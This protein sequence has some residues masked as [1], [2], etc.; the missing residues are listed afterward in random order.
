MKPESRGARGGSRCPWRRVG[1]VLI[2]FFL[3]T[4]PAVAGLPVPTFFKEFEPDLI[5]P[6]STS[7]LTFQIIN[8]GPDPVTDLAFTDNLPTGVV[9]ATPTSAFTSCT[10]G[11]LTAPAGGTT[12]DF[13]GGRLGGG[14]SCIVSVNV[15]SSVAETYTNVSGDLTSSAGNSGSA[16]ADLTV[17][18]SR[19]GFRKSFEPAAIAPHHSSTLTLTID[20]SANTE[21]SNDFS[22]TDTLPEGLQIASPANASTD[23]DNSFFPPTLTALPGTRAIGLFNG[24]VA[25]NSSC[26]VTVDVTGDTPAAYINNS[27]ELNV[28]FPSSGTAGFATA[29]LDVLFVFLNKIFSDDP[30]SPGQTVTLEFTATNTDR[31]NAATDIS[32]TDDLGAT[33]AG[34]EAVGLPLSDVCGPGSQIDGTSVL[35][36]TGGNIGPGDSCSFSVTLQVPGG[37]G[38][39]TYTNTT[40]EVTYDLDG[41]GITEDPATDFLVVA[42]VPILSK[43][44]IDDPV[45]PGASVTLEFTIENPTS[46][47]FSE[48]TFLDNLT[49]VTPG[50]EPAVGGVPAPGFCGPGSSAFLTGGG[51]D[52]LFLL[53]TE[54]ELAAGSSCTFQVVLDIPLGATPGS[55]LNT[56]S[57]ITGFADGSDPVEGPPASDILEVAGVPAPAFSKAFVDN[58]AIAG[59]AATL[60]FTIT[61]ADGT[62]GTTDLAFTDDLTA[63]LP[64]LVATGLPAADICG[65]G[66]TLEGTDELTF[67]GGS[68]S[69]TSSCTFQVTLV[70]PADATTGIYE[71]VTSTLTGETG[72][73]PF[74]SL[75]ATSDLVIEGP[76]SATKE[77]TDD[78]VV[79]GTQVTLEFT[80]TNSD[81]IDG[82][83]GISF[84]DDL[85]GVLPGLVAVGLPATNLCGPGSVLNGT[86]LLSFIG[87][88]LVPGGSCTFSVTLAVPGGTPAGAYVN[89][90]SVINAMSGGGPLNALPASDTLLVASGSS[91][92]LSKSFTDDP[93][94][95][96]GTATLEFSVDYL[97]G[98][99][100][101]TD[102]AFTDDLE[103]AL[104]GLTAVGLPMTDVCGPGSQIN[105][106]SLLTLSDGS[107]PVGGSCTFQVTVLVPEDAL[108]GSYTNVTSEITGND[109]GESINGAPASDDLLVTNGL[110]FNKLTNGEDADA[111]T[112]PMID[113]GDPVTW[114]YVL[115]NTGVVPAT[116]IEVEDSEGVLVSCPQDMLAP[117]ETLTCTGSGIATL[118]QYSNVGT[119]SLVAG[120]RP[121]VLTDP[122]HYLGVDT[123]PPQVVGVD[124]IPDTGDGQLE[125]CETAQ[126][127]IGQIL[128]TFDEPVQDPPG[129]SEP[130]DVT[131]PANYLLV[132]AGS[133]DDIETLEC[134]P[135][136]GDDLAIPI[137]M[138]SYD[139]GSLTATLDLGSSLPDSLH[140]LLVCGST[141]IRDLAGN[142]LDGNGD[143]M[144]G[145]DYAQI[146]RS[147]PGNLLANGHFDCSLVDWTVS[148]TIPGSVTHSTADI[149]DSSLSGAAEIFVADATGLPES[150]ALSQCLPVPAAISRSL[151]GWTRLTA[152]PGV[153]VGFTESCEFFDQADCN[154]S[155]LGLSLNGL[156]LQDTGGEWVLLAGQIEAPASAVS[157]LCSFQFDSST[158]NAFEA[159]LDSTRLD[160][161]MIFA[162]GFE[163]GD[164]SAWS[165]TE[166]LQ[167]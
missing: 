92:S 165:V 82:V 95:P 99:S 141:S 49:Q 68:L 119:A 39:D 96:G 81:I 8:N 105:G 30:V 132:A 61:T 166:P 17:D 62:E 128:V 120:T 90:T 118:G 4:L 14:G 57:Q 27:G 107:L 54:A 145:D 64:G 87:G 76:L 136:M 47:D 80:L 98:A 94:P 113:V 45:D 16:T 153:F 67:S 106:S 112:G 44:F 12:I 60:Q 6:G 22:F 43:S 125:D 1:G 156:L 78:P 111:P 161:S 5:G 10:D 65:S 29:Q 117:G 127:A 13:S 26:T 35:T 144:G 114:E 63:V 24:G 50:L 157:A 116:D 123:V 159:L 110:E 147:D 158:G 164:T 143:G 83:T 146:F 109:G 103:A 134:G 40:S 69:P 23:C 56:T 86:S 74:T 77:F 129:D 9:I 155:S 11:V 88:E 150:F 19:P 51:F 31:D 162:D 66:S 2:A 135:L 59:G 104:N 151:G 102:I 20:N 42:P 142:A 133:D 21:A 131:N 85:S 3:V 79:A 115:S 46:A 52:P 70:V 101:A 152:A 139:G 122:S 18:N 75:P 25:A 28:G 97:S 121:V 140:R 154:G 167:P 163:S 15:T 137:A 93:T 148:E 36:F 84:T 34:L 124:S 138:V 32:F 48:L 71:N 130:D 91:L 7:T 33:L 149:D 55:Y 160:N 100:T 38:F 108:A 72:G 41:L 73:V 58:P 37:A 53:F 126:E 89:T